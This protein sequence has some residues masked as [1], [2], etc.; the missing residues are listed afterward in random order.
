MLDIKL[1]QSL[2]HKN[3]DI[4]IEFAQTLNLSVS[5]RQQMHHFTAHASPDNCIS[6][7]HKLQPAV[8]S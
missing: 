7:R 3:F 6:T 1:F 8:V 4:I 5:T 2:M